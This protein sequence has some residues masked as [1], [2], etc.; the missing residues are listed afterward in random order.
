MYD[1]YFLWNCLLTW[2]F[3]DNIN[4][5]DDSDCDDTDVDIDFGALEEEANG[6]DI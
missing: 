3:S 6:S 1:W 2:L 4:L 5:L